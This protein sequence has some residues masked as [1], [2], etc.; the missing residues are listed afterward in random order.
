MRLALQREM[1]GL[2]LGLGVGVRVVEVLNGPINGDDCM[3]FMM[4]VLKSCL[5]LVR[6]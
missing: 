5:K 4:L 3:R 6:M 1:A 2:G